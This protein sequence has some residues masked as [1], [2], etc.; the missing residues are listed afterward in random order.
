MPLVCPMSRA[1]VLVLLVGLLA[2]PPASLPAAG[3]APAPSPWPGPG[4]AT[5]VDDPHF[6]GTDLSGLSYVAGATPPQDR[7]FAVRDDGRLFRLVPSGGQWLA[8]TTQ[9]WGR[10]KALALPDGRLGVDAEGVVVHAGEAWVSIERDGAGN[11]RPSILRVPLEGTGATLTATEEWDLAPHYPGIGANLG[12]ESVTAVPNEFLVRRGFLDQSTGR[13]FDPAAHPGQ[14]GGAVFLVAVE[15]PGFR[16]RV[17]AFVFG[18]AGRT[19]KVASFANPVGNVMDLD[20]DASAGQVWA[21]CDHFCDVRSAVFELDGGRFVTRSHLRRPSGLPNHNFEG[22]TLAPLQRC[23]DGTREVLWA[24]DANDAGRVL[25]AGRLA[26]PEGACPG[27]VSLSASAPRV[28]AGRSATVDVTV[29]GVR[30]VAEG[31]LRGT[32][33]GTL[34]VSV[35]TRTRSVRFDSGRATV[36]LGVFATAGRRRVQVRWSDGTHVA[37]VATTLV[38]RRATATL[39]RAKARVEVRAGERARVVAHLRAGGVRTEGRIRVRLVAG[40]RSQRVKATVTRRVTGSGTKRSTKVVVRTPRIR[41]WKARAPVKV[42]VRYLGNGDTTSARTTV[43][44]R[45][46]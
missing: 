22:F 21:S 34:S 3:A 45:V 26:C 5:A 23:V 25:W 1:A 15:A 8:D 39:R 35:G 37:S 13:A 11:A 16:D 17:D 12:P 19:T 7:V 10:G 40:K 41:G 36:D 24:N 29:R 9:G 4:T 33:R 30:G 38:V 18:P 32:L 2:V 42:V 31:T 28:A 44:L 6:F 46:R 27:A 43:T 20:F 14:R